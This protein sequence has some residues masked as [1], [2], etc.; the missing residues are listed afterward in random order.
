MNK[1]KFTIAACLFAS[2]AAL[3]GCAYGGVA[4]VDDDTVVILRNN[5]FLFGLLRSV[6]VCQV[7]D[8]GLTNCATS[9]RP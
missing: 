8:S 6:H 1:L 3:G 4:A 9:D 2:T 5:G 7:S